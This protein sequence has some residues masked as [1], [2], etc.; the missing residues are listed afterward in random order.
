VIGVARLGALV[1]RGRTREVWLGA[2]LFGLG[3]MALAFGWWTYRGTCPYLA[4]GRFLDEIRLWFPARMSGF[5]EIDD[6][7]SLETVRIL[8]GLERPIP[9]RFPTKTTLDVILRH[10]RD[11][12]RGADGKSIPIYVDPVGLQEAEASMTSTVT[13]DVDAVPLKTSL[14]L[15]LRQLG[16]TYSVKS[17]FLMIRYADLEPHI[18]QD[19]F[20]VVGH[21]LFAL[22]AAWL[23]GA[24]AVILGREQ[25]P[26]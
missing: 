11:S 24:A 16:L 15:A 17:G 22:I 18:E 12:T 6:P 4:T 19:S 3:Y 23:G 5:P 8:E 2:A 25:T 26:G 10:V 13:L 1:A 20:L 7:G 14:R 9:F 21:S